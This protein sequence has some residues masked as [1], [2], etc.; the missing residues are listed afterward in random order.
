[1]KKNW[2]SHLVKQKVFHHHK[3]APAPAPKNLLFR[4][5]KEVGASLGQV[6]WG[7]SRL[8]SEIKRQFYKFFAFLLICQITWIDFNVCLVQ[9]KHPTFTCWLVSLYIEKASSNHGRLSAKNTKPSIIC[10]ISH[11]KLQKQTAY[12]IWRFIANAVKAT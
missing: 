9:W 5:V 4:H 8:C 7:K 3:N 12:N 6:C 2:W 11:N 1:M 10:L